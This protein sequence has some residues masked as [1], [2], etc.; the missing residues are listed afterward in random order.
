[1]L[2]HDTVIYRNSDVALTKGLRSLNINN[3]SIYFKSYNLLVILENFKFNY[4]MFYMLFIIK[5]IIIYCYYYILSQHI[6][7]PQKCH[8]T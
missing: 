2:I 5:N 7:N 3:G 1:M 8:F 6:L 4:T